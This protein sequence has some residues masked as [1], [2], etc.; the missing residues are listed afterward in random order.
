MI[1]VV[2]VIEVIM[3]GV[4]K[5]KKCKLITGLWS[6]YIRNIIY[7]WITIKE[8]SKRKNRCGLG[9]IRYH[10]FLW[11]CCWGVLVNVLWMSNKQTSF[12][13]LLSR[14][15]NNNVYNNIATYADWNCYISFT[16]V[17]TTFVPK[18]WQQIKIKYA[19]CT[20]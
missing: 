13:A 17:W 19:K 1:L 12:S 20:I 5:N 15:N 8:Y 7:K 2:M 4:L 18:L 10:I 11:V 16:T 3:A 14:Y 6:I 9:G